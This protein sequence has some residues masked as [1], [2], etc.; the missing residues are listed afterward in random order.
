MSSKSANYYDEIYTSM[1]KDYAAE[2]R[3]A[4][5]IIKKYK[6][7]SGKRLLDIACGTGLHA[8]KFSRRYQVEGLDLDPAMIS[9]ARKNY[10]TIKFHCGDMTNFN[11]HRQFDVIVCLFSSM[12]Y[13]KSK[14]RLFQSIKTMSRHLA[15]GG[16]L[17]VEPWFT[18][19][20]WKVGHVGTI[21][22]EKP[23]HK[24]VRMSRSAR[25]GNLSTVEFE[26]LIGTPKSIEHRSEV[27]ELGLFTHEEYLDAFRRSGLEVV[28]D[29]E[30]L[31]GRGLYIGMKS[32]G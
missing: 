18:P 12:G 11:L 25:K 31:D 9:V 6:R 2:A 26:Y 27:H 24:I 13:V 21:L 20:Q 10:P 23:D 7:A 32:A 3:K 5:Q 19:K 4:H 14:T 22:V 1:G 28:H 29:P 15:P 17:L 16:V 8:D 30:G